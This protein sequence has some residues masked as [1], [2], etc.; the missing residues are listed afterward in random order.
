M[1]DLSE[2]A[3]LREGISMAGPHAP[4]DDAWQKKTRVRTSACQN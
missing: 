1:H 3:E 2:I 4:E